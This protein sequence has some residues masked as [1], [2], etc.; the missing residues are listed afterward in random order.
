MSIDHPLSRRGRIG[1]GVAALAIHVALALW[2]ASIVVRPVAQLEAPAIDLF[3]VAPDPP[4]VPA[5]RRTTS[6]PD[7][8]AAAAP[9][10]PRAIPAPIVVP[11]VLLLPLP[12]LVVVA[13]VAGT[14]AAPEAGAA[15]RGAGTGA[16]G[17]GA[18][19]GSGIGGTGGGAGTRAKLLRGTIGNRDYPPAARKAGAMGS[20]T[21][22][23]TVD[24]Q[25]RAGGCAVVVSSG[26]AALDAVTCRLI[27]ARFRYAPAR[28]GVGA[29]VEEV[30]GWR[31]RW[32]FALG[33][34]SWCETLSS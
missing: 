9:V 7:P 18:G 6:T 8:S 19:I 32:W 24:V 1:A 2:L 33:R 3:D 5:P 10:G 30:R 14:G 11:P 23:F 34:G 26:N 31:Q 27:E 13:P 17:S 25:A 21:V 20:V 28:D 22:R 16:G 15:T 4:V 12:P 29:A